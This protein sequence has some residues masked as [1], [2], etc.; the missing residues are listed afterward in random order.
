MNSNEELEE[1]Y[2]IKNEPMKQM[3]KK[4]EKKVEE[5]KKPIN[6]KRNK[7]KYRKPEAENNKI[8]FNNIED[9][10]FQ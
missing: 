2:K 1:Q 6:P 4:A 10:I 8:D 5:K 7:M 9:M 3:L